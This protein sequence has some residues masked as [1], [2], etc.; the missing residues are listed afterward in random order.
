MK[1]RKVGVRGPQHGSQGVI[2][3][4]LASYHGI[5]WILR[6]LTPSATEGLAGSFSGS[7]QLGCSGILWSAA[8]ETAFPGQGPRRRPEGRACQH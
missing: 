5:P 6:T 1:E 3:H 2:S 4:W 8:G 7:F